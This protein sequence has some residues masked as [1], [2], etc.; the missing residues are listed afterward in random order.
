MFAQFFSNIQETKWYAQFLAPV[1]DQIPVNSSLLD[2]G[3]GSGKMLELLAK[4][5]SVKCVG[6]DTSQEM[7]D[8]AKKKTNG[9]PIELIKI[10]PN[11]SLPFTDDQFDFVTICSVLFHMKKADAFSML[12]DSIRV[13]KKNG[14][15]IILTPTGKGGIF[16]LARHFLGLGNKSIFVWYKATKKNAKKWTTNQILKEYCES[17]GLSYSHQITLHGFAQLEIISKS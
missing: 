4:N 10:N 12:D 17:N 5:K 13:L 8:E 1:M 11:D 15:I 7:L 6:L 3:T 14:R 9:L 2:I 16:K